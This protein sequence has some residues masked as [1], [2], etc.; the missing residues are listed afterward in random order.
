MKKY[1]LYLLLG[2][3]FSNFSFAQKDTALTNAHFKLEKTI[4]GDFNYFNVDVLENIYVITSGNQ[5]QKISSNGDSLASYG[6]VKKYG[7]PAYIDVSN[8]LKI[9]VYYKTYSTIVTLDR[10]LTFIN[11]INLRGLQ[12]F[13]VNAIA[14]SYDNNIWLFDESNFKIK[15]INESGNILSE[16][17]DM[18]MVVDEV[19]TATQ[20]LE[21][22]NQVLLY[23]ENKGFFIFDFYG[24][25]KNII[26]FLHWKNVAIGNKIIYGFDESKLYKYELN[27]L[28]LKEYQLPAMFTDYKSI[29]ALNGKL[30][31]LKKNGIEIYYID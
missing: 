30:Y 29:K 28:N 3:I 27:S 11:S 16:G 12:L 17:Q 15:K 23:D 19:P 13:N 25:Y 22:N 24:A 8:P 20:I 18:R 5:L 9:L 1:I 4:V 21:A 14:T 2:C 10:L 31:L 26:P 6:N 7:N